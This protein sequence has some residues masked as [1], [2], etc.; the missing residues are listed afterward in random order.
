MIFTIILIE[1]FTLTRVLHQVYCGNR[2]CQITESWTGL[3]LF[4]RAALA[5]P[6]AKKLKNMEQQFLPYR[7]ETWSKC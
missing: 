5:M 7:Y 4:T 1:N 6:A 2:L 3:K